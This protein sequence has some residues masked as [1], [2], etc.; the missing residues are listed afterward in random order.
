MNFR[1]T[2]L[3][4]LCLLLALY[5]LVSCNGETGGPA[6]GSGSDAASGSGSGEEQNEPE[7][8]TVISIFADGAAGVS[9]VRASFVETSTLNIISE[10]REE[11][12]NLS[13]TAF[14]IGTDDKE[15][16]A[17][18]YEIYIGEASCPESDAILQTLKYNDYSVSVSGNK[19]IIAAHNDTALQKAV[20]YFLNM[21]IVT[22]KS[23]DGTVT[24]IRF[25]SANQKEWADIYDVGNMSI[26]GNEIYQYRIVYPEA[27]GNSYDKGAAHSIAQAIGGQTGYYLEVVSDQTEASP[28]EILVGNTNRSDTE[29]TVEPLHG[30]AHIEGDRLVLTTGGDFS[31]GL[32]G[33]NFF[34]MFP[35]DDDGNVIIAENASVDCSFL[36]DTNVTARAE[37]T[38]MRIMDAN[39]LAEYDSWSTLPEGVPPVPGYRAEIFLAHLALYDPDVVGLQEVS[40]A[41]VKAIR[42]GLDPEQYALIGVTSETANENF[43][44]ILYRTDRYELVDW[45]MYN[46]SVGN[47]ARCRRVTW[48]VF[49]DRE[50]GERFALANTHWDGNNAQG[51]RQSAEIAATIN[52]IAAQYQCPVFS[53]GDY[54]SNENTDTYK[55]L[56]EM[57]GMVNTKYVAEDQI[58]NIGSW[59]ELNQDT[60]SALSCD[61]IFATDDCRVLAFQTLMF[62]YQIHASDHA[63]LYADIQFEEG[64]AAPDDGLIVVE[65]DET[66][67]GG[68]EGLN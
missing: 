30:S 52:G 63:W 54:N 29:G 44:P 51:L 56:M 35:P 24:A 36:T 22:D 46:Y 2:L 43:S 12:Y 18:A 15:Y 13:G 8:E 32:L 27:V 17:D 60:P 58:N 61:H 7:P 34:R 47:N 4:L 68:F 10:L 53:T 26:A 1:D 57:T 65:D 41:W 11:L 23:E 48:A 6:P 62:Y 21:G 14:R 19:I 42:E 28:Y 33:R 9:L 5:L 3:T 37:G 59:H 45:D 39:I 67:F 31:V 25:S 64:E 20:N 49:E 40:P 66:D 55:Q 16:D 38:D 50:T